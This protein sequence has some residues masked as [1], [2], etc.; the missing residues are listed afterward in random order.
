LNFY[1]RKSSELQEEAKEPEI[2]T[3]QIQV[4]SNDGVISSIH[5]ISDSATRIGFGSTPRISR[6]N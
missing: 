6:M 5:D 2:A 1:A 3:P 4:I